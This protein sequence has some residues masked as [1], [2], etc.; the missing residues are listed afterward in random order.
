MG[1]RASYRSYSRQLSRFHV[2]F[3]LSLINSVNKY[4]AYL[5]R[6]MYMVVEYFQMCNVFPKMLH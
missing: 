6:D 1:N 4:K 5:E 3:W 2:L